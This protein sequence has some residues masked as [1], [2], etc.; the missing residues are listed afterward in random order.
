MQIIL[1]DPMLATGGSAKAAIQVLVNEY[2]VN[3]KN[4]VFANMISCPEG[5]RAMEESYPDVKIVTACV[6]EY[7]NDDKYIVP[8]LGD[9]GDRFFNTM[10]LIHNEYLI[11][12]EEATRSSKR[13]KRGRNEILHELS[14]APPHAKK[15]EGTKWNLT[16]A[17]RYQQYVCKH[18]GCSIRTRNFCRCNPGHWM[19]K[20]CF[21]LHIMREVTSESGSD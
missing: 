8:G 13:R 7:L 5:I 3:T 19:C 15:F 14:S 11:T 16:A 21:P 20:S 4:I 9:Y 18:P 10:S 12:E 2:N 6:D 1:C 17:A